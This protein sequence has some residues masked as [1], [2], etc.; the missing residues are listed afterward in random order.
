MYL[1][2]VRTAFFYYY[3]NRGDVKIVKN[4]V[5]KDDSQNYRHTLDIYLPKDT[6]NFPT[7]HFIHG[8]NW[9]SGNKNYYEWLTGLYANIGISLAKQGIGVVIQNYRLYPEVGIDEE[10][11]DVRDGVIWTEK[12]IKEYGGGGAIFLAGHSAG[13]NI[14]AL[15]ASL[16]NNKLK[17]INMENI[18]GYIALSAVWDIPDMAKN[19]SNS[20]NKNTVQPIFG[21][22]AS[23]QEKY[24]PS[25][26]LDNIHKPIFIAVGGKDYPYLKNQALMA[27]NKLVELGKSV[28][29]F[30][31][32]EY[33]HEAMV[34]RFGGSSDLLA[35]KIVEFIKST[36]SF[37]L[38]Y[39]K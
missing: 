38:K 33:I 30:V 29:Y 35:P 23:E 31:A 27:K 20:F 19:T 34:V 2:N 13:G 4:I 1:L 22:K 7:A 11:A 37:Y 9:N 15:I 5:Y 16:E 10:I 24:S 6:K 32:P 17:A 8:G 26:F 3:K 36:Y 28:E 25:R 12:N 39:E 14:I 18:K 21:I